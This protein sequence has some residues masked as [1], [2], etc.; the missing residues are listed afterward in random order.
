MTGRRAL[1][2]ALVA[3]LALPQAGS[4]AASYEPNDPLAPKQWHLA[5]NRAFEFWATLPLLPPVRVAV[6]DSGIDAGHPD[7][8]DRIAEARSFVGG[9]AR[10]DTSGHGTFVAGL[11]AAAVDN[12][13]GVAGMAPS[14]ELLVAEARHHVVV[15]HSRR[16]HERVEDGRADEVEAAMLEVLRHGARGIGL[17]REVT[18]GCPSVLHR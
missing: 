4:G 13:E 1:L 6:I 2:A 7:L 11:I 18:K 14:A 10:E 3:I 5:A 8:K 15:D 9:S 17:G 12:A 16:L